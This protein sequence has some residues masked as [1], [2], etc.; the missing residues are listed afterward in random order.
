MK[1]TF[2]FRMFPLIAALG[3]LCACDI[4]AVDKQA[5]QQGPSPQSA[6][7]LPPTPSVVQVER[8]TSAAVS[9]SEPFA[10]SAGAWNRFQVL[11][12][13]VSGQLVVRRA[14]FDEKAKAFATAE[15]LAFSVHGDRFVDAAVESGGLYVYEWGEG[16][17]DGFKLLG[18]KEVAIPVDLDLSGDLS[19]STENG[20]KLFAARVYGQL[21]FRAGSV[22]T[23]EGRRWD[24]KADRVKFEKTIVRSFA[25]GA[26]AAEGQNGRDGGEILLKTPSAEGEVRFELRGENGGAGLAGP[27]PGP[28]LKGKTG[29]KGRDAETRYL[30]R[31][32]GSFPYDVYECSIQPTSGGPGFKGLKGLPGFMGGKGGD[33]AILTIQV[34]DRRSLDL[35]FISQVGAGGP[36]GPGGAGGEGGD[37][38]KAGVAKGSLGITLANCDRVFDGAKGDRGDWGDAGSAGPLGLRQRVCY[39]DGSAAPVCN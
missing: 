24:L 5:D 7:S 3:V 19:P 30:R 16:G 23:T 31:V 35:S 8:E 1:K 27:K 26:T 2:S 4:R 33:S 20:R 18:R 39:V 22:V 36:G 37:G 25:P 12:P 15:P 6:P 28:E 34:G 38:G 32:Y 14:R 13:R 21:I 29:E 17:A 11:L 10:Q 9:S